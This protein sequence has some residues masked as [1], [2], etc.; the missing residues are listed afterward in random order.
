MSSIFYQLSH[1]PAQKTLAVSL[2]SGS[3]RTSVNKA[4]LLS[5]HHRQPLEDHS[6]AEHILL[7]QAHSLRVLWG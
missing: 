1:P 2:V 4:S 5:Q 3:E 7:E 6:N